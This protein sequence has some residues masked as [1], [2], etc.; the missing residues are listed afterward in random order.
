MPSYVVDI[1]LNAS[2]NASAVM[3]K[4][5]RSLGGVAA[6]AGKVLAG[7]LIA[8][9]VALAAF[10]VKAIMAGSDAEETRSKFLTV[11]KDMS[12]SVQTWSDSVANSMG[13]TKTAALGMLASTQDLLVPMGLARDQAAGLSQNVL[14]LAGD[15][16]SFNNVDAADVLNDINS[17]LV[18]ESEP[19]K[20]YGV[21]VSAAAVEA[22]ALEMGLIG[23]GEEL[24]NTA[25]A[26]ATMQIIMESTTDAQGDLERT[27]DSFANK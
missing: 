14:K 19:M 7:G 24:T 13:L 3:D 21:L 11:F 23:Q 9:G 22:K 20:K 10:S 8:G 18:G 2:G 4:T 5:R 26:M 16:G 27:Q 17:A 1:V 15:M 12:G 25:R 6:T